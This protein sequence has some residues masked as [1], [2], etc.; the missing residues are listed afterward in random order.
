MAGNF[1][2]H[3]GGNEAAGFPGQA[4]CFF[5]AVD[6]YIFPG[7]P[8]DLPQRGFLHPPGPGGKFMIQTLILIRSDRQ[9]IFPGF[10][11]FPFQIR[12]GFAGRGFF[13]GVCFRIRIF[14]EGSSP[15]TA[16]VFPGGAVPG[17]P[18]EIGEL[19][20]VGKS[21]FQGDFVQRF[22]C[23]TQQ[24]DRLLTAQIALKLF[25][26]FVNIPEEKPLQS[27][28]GDPQFL[29]D[30][31]DGHLFGKM[32]FNIADCKSHSFIHSVI[33][34]IC[35][36]DAVQ[37]R[38]IVTDNIFNGKQDPVRIRT[39]QQ[40]GQ[41][42]QQKSLNL[43]N[44]IDYQAKLDQ[45]EQERQEAR[46]SWN[47][48]G[49][50]KDLKA[51]Y[52][53]GAVYEIVRMMVENNAIIVMEDLNTGFKRGRMKIEK[54]IYQKFEKAL[55]D[56]L[57]YLVFKDQKDPQAPG[58]VL[59]GYQ[60]ANKFESFAKLGKQCGFIFYVPAGFTSKIDPATGFVNIFNTKECTNADSIK[61]FFDRFD[62]ITYSEKQ[63][64]FAFEFD[65]RKFKTYQEDFRNKWIVYTLRE[66]WQQEKDPSNGKY[67]P[68]RHNP[69]KE[70]KKAVF[71]MGIPAVTDGFDLLDLLRKT[72]SSKQTASF[73]NTVFYAFKHSTALRHTREQED[74]IISPVMNPQGEFF[75]SRNDIENNPM[76]QDADANGAFHIALKGVYLLKNCI[77]GGKVEKISNE[78]W[79]KF[80]QTRNK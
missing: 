73:F 26:C 56:K 31:P 67:H 21:Q 57:N 61:A 75:I 4:D 14:P 3:P 19:T 42:L 16:S 30:L 12:G 20:A 15:G 59:A 36:M 18:E 70:I 54:Q 72:E 9:H 68:I 71:S 8:E 17:F 78:E 2:T 74:Q 64:A 44:N 66:A 47:A 45:R 43:I 76:P 23:M 69:T 28:L 10:E 6:L 58:G 51:G 37:R 77:K 79:L 24:M 13:R 49:K 55:I 46:K 62:S 38:K 53:S 35:N 63:Q 32:S 5:P 60:L 33:R 22:F 25:R 52:L 39:A 50:I 41:I 7:C 65:Y 40:T 27:H 48:I 11:L 29:T 80:A 1:V 34:E